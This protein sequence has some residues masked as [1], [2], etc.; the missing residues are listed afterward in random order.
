MQT[1]LKLTNVL[2]AVIAIFLGL[3]VV[4]L[5]D[6]PPTAVAAPEEGKA[7]EEGQA[8]RV[9]ISNTP[10]LVQLDDYSVTAQAQA[11]QRVEVNNL[12]LPVQLSQPT[13]VPVQLAGERPIRVELYYRAGDTWRPVGVDRGAIAVR[14]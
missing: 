6:L 5:Y 7:V 8:Q 14:Q 3:I 1:N 4:R 12:P 11:S 9:E 10:V 2:L 13:P